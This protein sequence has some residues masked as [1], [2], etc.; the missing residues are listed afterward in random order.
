MA[1]NP[2]GHVPGRDYGLT[3]LAPSLIAS[4]PTFYLPQI[5]IH[6]MTGQGD[7]SDVDMLRLYVEML[8]SMTASRS[9]G[10]FVRR[11]Y[12]LSLIMLDL[13]NAVQET[14]P[15]LSP[16]SHWQ[17]RLAKPRCRPMSMPK[18][19]ERRAPS[20]PH[21]TPFHSPP[22]TDDAFTSF[23]GANHSTSS[24]LEDYSSLTGL[25]TPQLGDAFGDFGSASTSLG[26]ATGA[27]SGAASGNTAFDP[28]VFDAGF[29][30]DMLSTI[31]GGYD[32]VSFE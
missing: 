29:A 32:L 5:C 13:V 6:I 19:K 15:G 25:K 31:A 11:L 7:K 12:E 18:D 1:K 14:P 28:T 17:S 23:A 4:Y 3:I 2:P 27:G 21:L 8:Q 22:G 20:W 10:T 24:M 26:S 16:T 9:R 30:A